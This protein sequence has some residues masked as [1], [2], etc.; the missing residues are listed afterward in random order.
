MKRAH[1]AHKSQSVLAHPPDAKFKQLIDLRSLKNCPVVTNNVTNYLTISGPNIPGLGGR[2]TQNKTA[3]VKP[4]YVGIPKV[5][6]GSHQYVTVCADVMFVN[7]IH[8]LR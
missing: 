1:L 5:L 4:G 6:Y 2:T 3:R 8:L 7:E